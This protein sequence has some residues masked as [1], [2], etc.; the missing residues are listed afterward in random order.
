MAGYAGICWAAPTTAP[1]RIG[2]LIELVVVM[3]N[4]AHIWLFTRHSWLVR[5]GFSFCVSSLVQISR[6]KCGFEVRRSAVLTHR[7][8]EEDKEERRRKR[9]KKNENERMDAV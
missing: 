4:P 7:M 5:R 6:P 8:T 2:R 3:S 9:E 1:L